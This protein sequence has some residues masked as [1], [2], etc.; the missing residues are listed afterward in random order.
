MF[1]H[2]LDYFRHFRPFF[3]CSGKTVQL[4]SKRVTREFYVASGS[5]Y[6]I[7]FSLALLDTRATNEGDEEP[8]DEATE[9]KGKEEGQV[10]GEAE[11]VEDVAGTFGDPLGV[12]GGNVEVQNEE[13]EDEDEDE[14]EEDEED[15]DD[16]D[17]DEEEYMK[18]INKQGKVSKVSSGSILGEGIT[19]QVTKVYAL[20]VVL[21]KREKPGRVAAAKRSYVEEE[22]EE[23]EAIEAEKKKKSKF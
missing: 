2:M 16:P 17:V 5:H 21:Q 9:D 10:I 22:D 6:L 11:V 7:R 8:T 18:Q 15:E 20:Q 14:D 4:R 1:I 19:K 13:E 23:D 3:T 12:V